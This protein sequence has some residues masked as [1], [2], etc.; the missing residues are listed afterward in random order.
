MTDGSFGGFLSRRCVSLQ[1]NGFIP[2]WNGIEHGRGNKIYKEIYLG[3]VHS[4]GG[5]TKQRFACAHMFGN[6]LA[7]VVPTDFETQTIEDAL[8]DVAFISES[9]DEPQLLPGSE[10]PPLE[11]L[12][13][14]RPS[15][16]DKGTRAF[17]SSPHINAGDDLFTCAVESTPGRTKGIKEQISSQGH[18]AT[19]AYISDTVDKLSEP[20]ETSLIRTPLLRRHT[21]CPDPKRDFDCQDNTF[22]LSSHSYRLK[23]LVEDPCLHVSSCLGESVFD[24]ITNPFRS[25]EVL[26]GFSCLH[27]KNSARN[28]NYKGSHSHRMH[29]F[30][31]LDLK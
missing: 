8:E 25:S 13:N 2:W 7:G 29:H 30:S 28:N 18:L 22:K 24:G 17:P 31:A 14:L 3:F 5:S 9:E 12:F 4:L 26:W 6:K 27:H 23:D 16:G 11:I 10:V 15:R 19:T 20:R 21:G 1:E